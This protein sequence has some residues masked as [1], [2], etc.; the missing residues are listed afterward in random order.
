[1]STTRAGEVVLSPAPLTRTGLES[2]WRHLLE[3]VCNQ[4]ADSWSIPGDGVLCLERAAARRLGTIQEA[5]PGGGMVAPP[6]AH[7]A[8]ARVLRR[9]HHPVGTATGSAGVGVG[10]PRRVVPQRAH[11]ADCD[12]EAAWAPDRPPGFGGGSAMPK[13][14]PPRVPQSAASRHCYVPD[15]PVSGLTPADTSSIHRTRWLPDPLELPRQCWSTQPAGVNVRIGPV[16]RDRLAS[17][18]QSSTCLRASSRA[19]PYR[20]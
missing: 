16:Y 15:G 9:P 6:A 2:G 12:F 8:D 13:L 1:M 17:A 4:S 19:I 5:K 14:W 10:A 20:S 11:R 7:P 18:A 3:A